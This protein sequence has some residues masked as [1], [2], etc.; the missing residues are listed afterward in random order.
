[1]VYILLLLCYIPYLSISCVIV[2]QGM[3][4]TNRL[5]FELMRTVVYANSVMNPLIYC[6]R[7][8][9]IRVA[10]I[11]RLPCSLSSLFSGVYVPASAQSTI[12]PSF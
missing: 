9:D 5:L 10:V 7:L 3:T 2:A 1:M 4:N 11:Q 12:N 8:R 6:W